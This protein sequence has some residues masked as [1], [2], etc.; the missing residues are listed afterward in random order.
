MNFYI[1]ETN[2]PTSVLLTELAADSDK[3]ITRTDFGTFTDHFNT[4][5]AETCAIFRLNT[6]NNKY[7]YM[8]SA[9]KA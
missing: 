5:V 2:F 9:E 3:T 8:E 1:N 4:I 6:T 7:E